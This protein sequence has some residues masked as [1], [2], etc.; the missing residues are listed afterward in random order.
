M[1]NFYSNTEPCPS[2][3]IK[4]VP[5]PKSKVATPRDADLRNSNSCEI[6][7]DKASGK[8]EQTRLQNKSFLLALHI[9]KSLSSLYV[10]CT[11]WLDDP[12]RFWKRAISILTLYQISEV[13]IL[14]TLCQF[15]STAF[16][17]TVMEDSVDLLSSDLALRCGD[18]GEADTS[19][20]ELVAVSLTN[21]C[22][23]HRGHIDKSFHNCKPAS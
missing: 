15:L 5:A 20:M 19:R 22:N 7:A 8:A 16:G 14:G 18:K 3:C 13:T 1:K 23:K 17:L 21:S 6:E 2:Y 11:I 10:L 4:H 12:T 9:M